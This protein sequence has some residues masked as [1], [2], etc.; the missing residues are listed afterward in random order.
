[1]FIPAFIALRKIPTVRVDGRQSFFSK[2]KIKQ[3]FL[4]VKFSDKKNFI[5]TSFFNI[6]ANFC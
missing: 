1:M 6:Q 5:F 2:C 3:N 4:T